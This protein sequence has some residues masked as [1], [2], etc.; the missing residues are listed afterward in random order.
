MFFIKSDLFIARNSPP[1]VAGCN[2]TRG[3][4]LLKFPGFQSKSQDFGQNVTKQGGVFLL[5]GGFLAINRSDN[6]PK[7]HSKNKLCPV[8]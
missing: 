2:K 6:V 8:Y 5:R 7:N 1:L 4:F 3:V